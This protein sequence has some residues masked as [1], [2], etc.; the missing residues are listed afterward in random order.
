MA[1]RLSGAAVG[2]FGGRA[3]DPHRYRL[4]VIAMKSDVGGGCMPPDVLRAGAG[5]R[6]A[7]IQVVDT[8]TARLAAAQELRQQ[9]LLADYAEYLR[10]RA[11][12]G[13]SGS[14]P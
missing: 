11:R 7:P 9:R 6:P 14:S 13:A 4:R 3:L 5:F 12:A 8:D 1:S 10:L 2:F